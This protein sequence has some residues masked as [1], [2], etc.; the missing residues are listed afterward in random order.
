MSYSIQDEVEDDDQC[1]DTR[2]Y[3]CT[4]SRGTLEDR[5]GLR[6][7]YEKNQIGYELGVELLFEEWKGGK[8]ATA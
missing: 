4:I 7:Q 3:P 1:K 8:V 6:A 5:S 2:S